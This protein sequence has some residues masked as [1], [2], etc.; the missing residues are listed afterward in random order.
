MRARVLW[1]CIMLGI[2][3]SM[4]EM[5]AVLA[6]VTVAIT[7]F[8]AVD[9]TLS[10]L[11]LRVAICTVPLLFPLASGFLVLGHQSGLGLTSIGDRLALV[12][13]DLR[14]SSVPGRATEVEVQQ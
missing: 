7:L 2:R 13:G 8:P 11:S 4:Y 9:P 5:A 6:A 3:I 12:G 14:I 10:A 1:G